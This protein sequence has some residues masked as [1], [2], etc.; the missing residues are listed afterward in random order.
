MLS[1]A[2]PTLWIHVYPYAPSVSW[3]WR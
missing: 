2:F 1:I 3:N